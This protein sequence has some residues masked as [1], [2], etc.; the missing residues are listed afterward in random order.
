M[1]VLSQHRVSVKI[2]TKLRL[3]LI[4]KD[5]FSLPLE[6]VTSMQAILVRE[7]F[8]RGVES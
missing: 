8:W 7:T 2:V 1:Q 4:G 6:L 3:L 5:S